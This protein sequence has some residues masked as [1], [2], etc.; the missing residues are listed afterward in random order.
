MRTSELTQNE[1]LRMLCIIRCANAR[2][3][4]GR[5]YNVVGLCAYLSTGPDQSGLRPCQHHQLRDILRWVTSR[6]ASVTCRVEVSLQSNTLAERLW[7]TAPGATAPGTTAPWAL[8]SGCSRSILWGT[9]TECFG[10]SRARRTRHLGRFG[11]L[12]HATMAVRSRASF[13]SV[14]CPR[15]L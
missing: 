10:R 3:N 14:A 9:G 11:L 15:T 2:E 4:R 1:R 7:T 13:R 5:Y 12:A 8:D 6:E